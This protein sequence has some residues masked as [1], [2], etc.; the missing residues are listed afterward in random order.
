MQRIQSWFDQLTI[1]RP[2]RRTS[3]RRRVVATTTTTSSKPRRAVSPE[4]RRDRNAAG[5]HHRG[6]PYRAASHSVIRGERAELKPV[7]VPIAFP[8]PPSLEGSF[9]R[10]NKI[11]TNPWVGDA[12]K[13]KVLNDTMSRSVG[14]ADFRRPP[15]TLCVASPDTS[16]CSSGYASHD[17][18]FDN[19]FGSKKEEGS[20]K[21]PD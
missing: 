7:P 2:T 10:R 1:S 4:P 6:F 8:P 16:V 18:R 19:I 5:D 15:P 9:P 11:R 17:S 12:K 14:P 21:Q 20:D 3:R 13:P